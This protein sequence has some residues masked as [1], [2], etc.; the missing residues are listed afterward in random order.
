MKA[1]VFGEI[2]WDIIEGQEYLGGAPLNFAAHFTQCGAQASIVSAVGND[3]RGWRAIN[4]ITRLKID[5]SAVNVLTSVPTGTV[6][7]LLHDGE[8][9]YTITEKVAYDFINPDEVIDSL[10][11]KRFDV[12]YFGTLAQRS[13]QSR[14][15]L[16]KILDSIQF[17]HKFYDVNLRKDSYTP[18][19]IRNGLKRCSIFKLNKEEVPVISQLLFKTSLS[20][21]LF[22]RFITDEFNIEIVIITAAAQGCQIYH[23]NMLTNIPGVPVQVADAV[24]AGD[25]FSAAFM[26]HY[27]YSKDPLEA[28]RLANLI[29]SYVA[30]K[31]GPIPEYS[32]DLLQQ[33]RKFSNQPS[34]H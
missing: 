32:P 10:R 11:K 16:T 7:V 3:N 33:I 4:E 27:G 22:C 13:E 18:I 21:E 28:A 1:L 25:A 14:N 5:Y 29:G 26:F 2:L 31:S 6:D 8:P 12:F 34:Q 30:G 24:G 9:T 23:Q 17:S 20:T 19:I 15:A